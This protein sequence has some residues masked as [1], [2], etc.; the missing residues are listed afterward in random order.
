MNSSDILTN[1]KHQ[2]DIN[3]LTLNKI[4]TLVCLLI[5]KNRNSYF[6]RLLDSY[7]FPNNGFRNSLK[8]SIAFFVQIISIQAVLLYNFSR[9]QLCKRLLSRELLK[10]TRH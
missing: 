4:K 1:I 7:S 5:T 8:L 2:H 10:H 3:K 9:L 6:K